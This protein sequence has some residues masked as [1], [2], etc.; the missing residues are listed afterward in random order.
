MEVGGVEPATQGSIVSKV[1]IGVLHGRGPCRRCRQGVVSPSG[2]EVDP[3][4]CGPCVLYADIG[5]GDARGRLSRWCSVGGHLFLVTRWA[6]SHC[7][8]ASCELR[9][10]SAAV[11][12]R[13]IEKIRMDMVSSVAPFRAKPVNAWRPKWG[14]CPSGL[15]HYR[16]GDKAGQHGLQNQP[17][18]P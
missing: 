6:R 4:R 5:P 14:F 16:D 17:T 1:S 11:V 15:D 9:A 13:R 7:R 10:E 12:T 2:P 18:R 8:A 3:R